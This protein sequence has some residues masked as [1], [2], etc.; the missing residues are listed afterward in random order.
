M[1]EGCA[2][3]LGGG[4][5][6]VWATV[7]TVSLVFDTAGHAQS[8]SLANALIT[9]TVQLRK[10]PEAPDFIIVDSYNIFNDF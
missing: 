8:E 5:E 3:L 9:Q 10:T 7:T 6:C 2:P 4:L 1:V